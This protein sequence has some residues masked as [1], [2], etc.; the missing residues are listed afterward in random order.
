[1]QLEIQLPNFSCPANM[2]THL[3]YVLAGEYD[4]PFN[5]P[6]P[7]ILDLGA[8]CGAFSV[9]AAHR[10]PGSFIHAYEPHR[11]IFDEYL[12]P[13]TKDYPV[14]LKNYGIGTP[15]TRILYDGTH[16]IGETSFHMMENN[17]SITG[18]HAEVRSP[19]ELPE[20]EILKMDI[21]G[22]EIEVLAPLIEDGRKFKLILAE[23]HHHDYRLEMDRLLKKDYQL[24]KS[25][26]A[27]VAG[28]GTV[29]YAN[30][31]IL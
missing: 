26:V 18:Q 23:Y 13:N 9:W 22:C 3:R 20:A 21:E 24:V 19:L 17:F 29:A 1:M 11:G 28:R 5:I 30:K 27:H 31:E 10:W 16:N 25:S 2:F 4:V 7:R 14:A 8:N 15:G 6:H 12:T